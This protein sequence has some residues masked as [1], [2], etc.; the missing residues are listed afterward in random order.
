MGMKRRGGG[1]GVLLFHR[2]KCKIFIFH[3]IYIFHITSEIK[4]IINKYI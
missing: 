3:D 4:A 2:V 1:G